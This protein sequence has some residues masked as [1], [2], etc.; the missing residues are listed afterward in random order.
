MA[1]RVIA[2][3]ASGQVSPRDTAPYRIAVTRL[4]QESAEVLMEIVAEGSS[5]EAGDPF[6]RAVEDHWRYAQASTVSSGSLQMQR[7]LTSRAMLAASRRTSSPTR[8]STTTARPCV[9]PRRPVATSSCTG[10]RRSPPG[11]PG[12][13]P[14]VSPT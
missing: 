6:R 9:P 5:G 7:I 2:T 13:D 4:D 8:P 14:P 1:Y 3:Q 12:P 11:A 10:Q